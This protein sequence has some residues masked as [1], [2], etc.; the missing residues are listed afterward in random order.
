MLSTAGLDTRLGDS[1]LNGGPERSIEVPEFHMDQSTATTA[2]ATPIIRV[3]SMH[4][5]IPRHDRH[6]E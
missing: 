5:S 2:V 3:T 6:L 4:G 1:L